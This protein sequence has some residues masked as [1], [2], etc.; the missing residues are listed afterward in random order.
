MIDRNIGTA[1]RLVRFALAV[2]LVVW[3]F[4]SEVF[5]IVQ[6]LALVASFALLW[7]SIFARCYLWKWLGLNSC[8]ADCDP[9]T[10]DC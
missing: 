5:G 2:M 6:A 10:Q 4:Y 1:E 7:N 8:E 3:I 9:E